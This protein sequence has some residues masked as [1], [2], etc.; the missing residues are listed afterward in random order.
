MFDICTEGYRAWLVNNVCHNQKVGWA[1]HPRAVHLL[2]IR[3]I[4]NWRV[5]RTSTQ[6]LQ[7][8][9]R[10]QQ[11]KLMLLLRGRNHQVEMVCPAQRS[12]L[13]IINYTKNLRVKVL[14]EV[15]KTIG[16][17][18]AEQVWRPEFNPRFSHPAVGTR[19][20]NLSTGEMWTCWPVCPAQLRGRG[21]NETPCQKN[22]GRQLLRKNR[23][24]WNPSSTWQ[25]HTHVQ[26]CTLEHT[27]E[28]EEE[29][30]KG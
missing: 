4:M 14:V 2:S 5:A 21:P 17:L 19:A 12:G 24:G 10:K 20:R 8:H 25:L 18:L 15:A 16:T 30:S 27:Q 28:V 23:Q 6:G 1:W 11:S 29:A 9:P 13:T 7:V 26:I 22:Q 3:P